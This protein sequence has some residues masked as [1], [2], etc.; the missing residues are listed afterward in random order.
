MRRFFAIS[1][2]L[3]SAVCATAQTADEVLTAFLDKLETTTLRSDISL[4]VADKHTQ[5]FTH[6]GTMEMR[7]ELFSINIFGTDAAY[8]G[9]TLYLYS[10]DTDE[11]TLTTPTPDELTEANPML[12]ARALRLK[13]TARFAATSKDA[14]TY[15]I[16]IIPDFREADVRKFV[17]RFAKNT[18]LPQ[19][20]EVV[21]T[22]QTLTLLFR[23]PAFVTTPPVCTISHPE[24]TLVDLR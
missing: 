23:S 22:T 10:E 6:N 20:I 1:I 5:P 4:S 3:L 14:N 15:N 13:S 11:L 17:L 2:V 12:F 19:R 21:E 9:K 7:G 24:A 16:E 8:D 18:F